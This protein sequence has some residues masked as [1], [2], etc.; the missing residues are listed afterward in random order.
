MK[1]N[2]LT[3]VAL[4]CC[5]SVGAADI[6]LAAEQMDAV[7]AGSASASAAADAT[8]SLLGTTTTFTHTF[9]GAPDLSAATA[10]AL[11]LQQVAPNIGGS[12]PI[13]PDADGPQVSMSQSSS[14]AN[15]SGTPGPAVP[16]PSNLTR[17]ELA[18]QRLG[19]L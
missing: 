4:T 19:L 13:G 3:V 14:S 6:E 12:T 11:I 9:T 10:L 16:P 17:S 18:L 7:T 2:I 15:G 1:T 8:G 5:A